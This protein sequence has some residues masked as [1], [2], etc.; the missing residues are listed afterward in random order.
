MDWSS[1][2][3][4]RLYELYKNHFHQ[5]RASVIS[6]NKTLG[7]GN[8]EKTRMQLMTKMEFERILT[9]KTD[10]PEVAVRWVKRIISG[11]EHEFPNLRVA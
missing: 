1:T 4:D 8:P 9:S 2:D 6:A 7:S 3:L 11:H 10:E 5:L